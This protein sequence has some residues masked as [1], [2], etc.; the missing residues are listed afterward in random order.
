MPKH[1][2]MAGTAENLSA[3]MNECCRGKRHYQ[4]ISRE[5]IGQVLARGTREDGGRLLVLSD[6]S[7]LLGACHFFASHK[8]RQGYIAYLLSLP[9]EERLVWPALLDAAHDALSRASTISIGSPYTPLYQAVEGR[10]QPLWGSTETLEV[11]HADTLLKDFLQHRGYNI[12]EDYVTM[13]KQ[14]REAQEGYAPQ[15]V[16][17]P[18][19]ATLELL[20]GE[21]CWY[22]AYDWYGQNSLGEFGRRNNSLMVLLLRRGHYI[23]GH[24]AWYPMRHV[25][26]VA[27]CDFEVSTEHRRRGLG[28]LLLT[29][30]LHQLVR[31]G[32]FE[33]EL[34][35]NPRESPLALALY[36]KYGFR[37]AA[38]WHEMIRHS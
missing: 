25:G 21:E 12:G 23:L 30:T 22:N 28:V 33:C 3:L 35:V 10:F 16:L 31:E 20:R 6:E 19:G 11:C 5:E 14:L 7:R 15:S 1:F 18:A 17:P 13:T 2:F 38:T 32:Y 9:G 36:H 27:L 34:L 24:T 29:Q 4:A 26:G 8:G 37:D